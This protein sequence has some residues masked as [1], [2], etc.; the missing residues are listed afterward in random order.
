MVERKIELRRRNSRRK[1]LLKLKDK[2][3]VAKEGK[4]KEAVLTK[5]HVIS[6][7]WAGKKWRQASGE[8]REEIRTDTSPRTRVSGETFADP[9]FTAYCVAA[10]LLSHHSPLAFITAAMSA[11]S[12]DIPSCRAAD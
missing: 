2:L 10:A 12:P 6:P 5:I 4:E 11:K 3:A 1:K 9:G 7:W 8:G